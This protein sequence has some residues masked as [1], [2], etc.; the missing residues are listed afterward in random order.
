[1]TSHLSKKVALKI[2]ILKDIEDI[3]EDHSDTGYDWLTRESSIDAIDEVYLKALIDIFGGPTHETRDT[4]NVSFRYAGRHLLYGLRALL[5]IQPDIS[6]QSL[7]D[8]MICLIDEQLDDF[9][10]W[11]TSIGQYF[12]VYINNDYTY[13]SEYNE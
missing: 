3:L 7:R 4:M 9:E 11:L 8:Y 13:A 12:R 6:F 10:V 2:R 1:M 5:K